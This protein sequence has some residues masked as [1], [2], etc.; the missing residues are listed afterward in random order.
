MSKGDLTRERILEQAMALAGSV[1]L[2]GLSIGELAKQTGLSKSGLFAHFASKEDLQLK[3][4]EAAK[5]RFVEEVVAPALR[6]PRGEPR[7][8]ALFERWLEWEAARVGGCPFVEASYELD[9]RPG[10]VRDAIAATQRDWVDTLAHAVRIAVDEKHLAPG[11]DTRQL[12]YELYGIFLAYH[13]YQRLL[14]DEAAVERARAAF[15][16]LLDS[17]R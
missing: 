11:T 3:I 12:A 4:L 8:R 5:T 13:L 1:G 9:D 14:E 17:S 15:E 6:A 10:P 7:L 2:E 16:R